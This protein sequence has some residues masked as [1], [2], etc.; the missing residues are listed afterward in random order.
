M[1]AKRQISHANTMTIALLLLL[2]CGLL[3]APVVA[4]NA[5]YVQLQWYFEASATSVWLPQALNYY[6]AENLTVAVNEGGPNINVEHYVQRQVADVGFGCLSVML[7]SYL[8]GNV[9]D[10]M[11]AVAQI[12]QT[13]SYRLVSLKS[14]GIQTLKD[15]QGKR[16]CMWTTGGQDLSIRAGLAAF[17]VTYQRI[18]LGNTPY[19]LLAGDC[20]VIEVMSYNE[21]GLLLQ[22]TNPATGQMVQYDDINIFDMGN[23]AFAM[24]NVIFVRKSWLAVPSNQ[25]LLRS[26]LR[27]VVRT[28]IFARDNPA[29]TLNYYNPSTNVDQWQL[30]ITNQM[31]WSNS[32]QTNAY[33]RV[34]PIQVDQTI[35][36]MI[37]YMS[38]T[39]N[40]TN[41]FDNT[42][43]DDVVAQLK[44][45]GY[46]F[47]VAVPTAQLSWCLDIG[48]T[49]PHVCRGDER[50]RRV[51]DVD[52]RFRTFGIVL[53]AILLVGTLLVAVATI[54]NRNKL[55][56]ARAAPN[57]LYMMLG[58]AALM[59]IGSIVYNFGVTITSCHVYIWCVSLGFTF[60]FVPYIC[61]TWR[62]Y[63]IFDKRTLKRKPQPP[64]MFAALMIVA[65]T[66][67]LILLVLFSS[68]KP[69]TSTPVVSPFDVYTMYR[70]CHWNH[71]IGYIIV[72]YTGALLIGSVWLALLIRNIKFKHINDSGDM[73]A[74]A[75]LTAAIVA[76]TLAVVFL[77]SNPNAS[78]LVQ[79]LG[80]CVVAVVNTTLTFRERLYHCAVLDASELQKRYKSDTTSTNSSADTR[81]STHD[82]SLSVHPRRRRQQQR[83]RR[84]DSV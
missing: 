64:L 16:I 67:D 37:T 3:C 31:A 56:I 73:S 18:S 14:S 27:A 6:A 83:H 20:D 54:L 82:F 79:S 58:G 41:V 39:L 23:A 2:F 76:F 66:V 8:T 29:K 11:I 59:Y 84:T 60:L 40:V 71:V 25:A 9:N 13:S 10:E 68:L 74:A 28:A 19:V 72:G 24:E 5:I 62:I 42:Y 30:Y 55:P 48:A 69:I 32:T 49:L 35:Q 53:C 63:R 36:N 78:V 1:S 21:L 51:M 43:I 15:M 12:D 38:P 47:D 75:F 50:T 26:F 61:K 52:K 46:R 45:E 57:Y 65:V 7:S 81:S 44:T 77:Q 34:N 22:M 4:D 80:I 33:G 70:T 17:N